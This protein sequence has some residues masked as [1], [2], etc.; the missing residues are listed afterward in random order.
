MKVGLARVSLASQC[1][2]LQ[3]DALKAA[4]CERIYEESASGAQRDR[5]QLQAALAYLRAGDSLV[6]W[7]LD[8]LARSTRQLLNT[9]ADLEQRDINFVSLTE[10]ID[11]SS[12]GGRFFFTVAAGM[13]EFERELIRERV[14]AGLAAA[15]AR[16]R[17][18][19]RPR[20]LSSEDLT[21]AKALL[22]DGELT[23]RQVAQR[24]GCAPSTLY[25]YL[26]AARTVTE[27][28]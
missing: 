16:G 19:G 26:P 27:E 24:V 2:D 5:P 12:P 18:G 9:I 1:R 21:V 3:V 20:A 23:V 14:N 28:R 25:A 6:V 10:Q 13:A 4:G 15:R 17:V 7:R 11:T 8:R 22:K